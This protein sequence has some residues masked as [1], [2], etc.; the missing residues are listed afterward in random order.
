MPEDGQLE[1]GKDLLE[2]VFY[3]NLSLGAD[4]IEQQVV[5]KAKGR[6]NWVVGAGGDA[7]ANIIRRMYARGF[8]GPLWEYLIR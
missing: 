3:R 1:A 8:S 2:P 7:T 5:E 4:D 6:A